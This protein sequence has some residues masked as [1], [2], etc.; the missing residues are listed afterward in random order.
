MPFINFTQPFA[1][2]VGVILF[3]LVLYLAK[4]NKKAWITG[5]MLFA[6]LALLV[7]HTVEFAA[8]PNQT[9]ET[10]KAIVTSATID[11]IFVF[12]SFISYLWIDDIEV[13]EGK[14]KS[15]DNSLDWFWNKV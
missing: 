3:V 4:E 9:E 6:F 2:I 15:I 14:K 8:I 11:L 13:K 1:I 7:A 5:L 12:L 10:Y